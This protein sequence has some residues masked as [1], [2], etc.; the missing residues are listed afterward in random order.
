MRKVIK[1]E[2]RF[3]MPENII[4][5]KHNEKL[6]ITIG[7]ETQV[8]P[9]NVFFFHKQ[10]VID[11]K[12]PSKE[13]SSLTCSTRQYKIFMKKYNKALKNEKSAHRIWAA[14]T[15]YI[16]SI[17][18]ASLLFLGLS[19][20]RESIDHNEIGMSESVEEVTVPAEA[21]TPYPFDNQVNTK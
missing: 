18:C 8:H 16:A 15:V 21:S 4:V 17:A 9:I 2:V 10:T 14:S 19:Q 11:F 7:S 6:H 20:H 5:T 3:K 12:G 1:T 13:T